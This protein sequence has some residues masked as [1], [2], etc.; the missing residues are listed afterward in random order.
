MPD[1]FCKQGYS[2]LTEITAE[3]VAQLIPVFSA[4]LPTCVGY[5][6]TPQIAGGTQRG[7]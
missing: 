5:A 3:N 1:R 7:Q 6:T 2:A 4:A